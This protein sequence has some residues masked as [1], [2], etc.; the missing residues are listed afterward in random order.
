MNQFRDL[1]LLLLSR[2]ELVLLLLLVWVVGE[3]WKWMVG[4]RVKGLRRN[5]RGGR[6][7]VGDVSKRIQRILRKG[8]EIFF[9][10]LLLIVVVVVLLVIYLVVFVVRLLDVAIKLNV[11]EEREREREGEI[12]HF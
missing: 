2:V 7:R 10:P 5:L 9:F 11:S 12:A 1:L 8:N 6:R 3:R 4:E